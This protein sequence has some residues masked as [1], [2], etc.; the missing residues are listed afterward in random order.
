[1]AINKQF[2]SVHTDY[3]RCLT[4]KQIVVQCN[5]DTSAKGGLKEVCFSQASVTMGSTQ[6]VAKQV[7]TCGKANIKVVFLDAEGMP[8]SFD[9]ISDFTED[10]NDDL[11]VAGMVVNV[12]S[13]VVDTECGIVG[14]EIRVQTVIELRPTVI[15]S[16]TF[17]LLNNAEGAL[18]QTEDCQCQCF[19]GYIDE[20]VAVVDEYKCG[21][22]I[23]DILLFDCNAII[24]D[25]TYGDSKQMVCGRC[26]CNII[27][28]SE[29][30]PANKT[31]VMPFAQEIIASED[32]V[33]NVKAS[34]KDC[35]LIILGTSDDNILRVE[36][37]IQLSGTRFVQSCCR[38]VKD[39]FS[40]SVEL[41]EK[42]K[43]VSYQCNKPMCK[44]EEKI[45]GNIN[46][47]GEESE[48]AQIMCSEVSSCSLENIVPMNKSALCEGLVAVN[49]LYCNVENQIKCAQIE[50]P[51][52][53]TMD[54]PEMTEGQCVVGN[55]MLCDL[56]AKLK[57]GREIEIVGLLQVRLQVKA[58][59]QLCGIIDLQEGE[60]KSANTNSIT[61]FIPS[62]NQTKWDI[63]KALGMPYEEIQQQ[64][65][66]FDSENITAQSR[67]VVYREL[68]AK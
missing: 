63:A 7:K 42:T 2:S 6:T 15:E 47:M 5:L 58:Q 34:V 48:I 61:I 27:Y 33:L 13:V 31:F 4:P 36:A 40:P 30:Q 60:V 54:C 45:S 14:N 43:T 41:I 26:I 39:I 12:D 8:K 62:H 56:S 17:E 51:F 57:R 16:Q 20:Q 22:C 3:E 21:V 46:I 44:C 59:A 65:P 37:L 28:V 68:A 52:S 25:V 32:E 23:N 10:I 50:I 1:M 9:Y 19:V 35:K 49:V 29:N 64:N 24:D 18:M 66:Y 67:I 38:V 55:C 11:L 53:L